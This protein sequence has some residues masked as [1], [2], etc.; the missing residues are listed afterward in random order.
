MRFLLFIFS[1]TLITPTLSRADEVTKPVFKKKTVAKIKKS[2]KTA[3]HSTSL[4]A[5]LKKMKTRVARSQAKHNQLVAVASVRG[6]EAQDPAPL[7][8][9]GK[10]SEGPVSMEE[11]KQFDAAIEAALQGD[12]NSQKQLEEFVAANPQ[13]P[14]V[15][16]ANQTLEMLKKE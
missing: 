1:L 3:K 11:L 15:A 8:W 6:S 12:A 16:E 10:T 5:W 7:Y 2:D 4:Q 14:L 9:K 13:S